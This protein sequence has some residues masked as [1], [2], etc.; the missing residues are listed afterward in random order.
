MGTRKARG[1]AVFLSDKRASYDLVPPFWVFFHIQ[2]SLPSFGLK[3]IPFL[4]EQHKNTV[5]SL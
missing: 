2:H 4:Y 3:T 5:N 1:A